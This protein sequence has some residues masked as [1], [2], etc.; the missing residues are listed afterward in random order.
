MTHRGISHT[1]LSTLVR[2]GQELPRSDLTPDPQTM[3]ATWQQHAHAEFVLKDADAALATM[4]ENPYVFMISSGTV[5]VGRAAVR[6]FYADHFLPQNPPDLEITSRADLR[7]RSDRR[8]NGNAIYTLGRNGL[9]TSRFATHKADCRV[10]PGRC[11][12][13]AA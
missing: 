6:E 4:A 12:H 2:C 8:R 9:D 11:Q 7:R 5:R 10:C 13:D 3:L 1:G